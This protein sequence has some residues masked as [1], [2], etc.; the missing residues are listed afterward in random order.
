MAREQSTASLSVAAC[1]ALWHE[2]KV[3]Q[4]IS[5]SSSL[6]RGQLK[7]TKPLGAAALFGALWHQSR[8][9]NL[10]APLAKGAKNSKPF[11]GKSTSNS[12]P[13]SGQLS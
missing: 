12:R 1:S 7:Y 5:G 11:V 3:Q 4:A 9:A 10:S 2:S 13:E 6:A 8:T